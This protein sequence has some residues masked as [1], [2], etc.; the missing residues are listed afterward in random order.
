MLSRSPTSPPGGDGHVRVDRRRYSPAMATTIQVSEA[1]RDRLRAL[2]AP[3]PPS[4]RRSSRH[5][6]RSSVSSSGPPRACAGPATRHGRRRAGHAARCG[7]RR[8]ELARRTVSASA[9]DVYLADARDEVRRRV[10]V[11]SD[12][13]FHQA[14]GRAIV[15]PSIAVVA[16]DESPWRVG[17]TERF[18]TDFLTTIPLDR[19]LEAVGRV[20]VATLRRA[21]R[22]VT[23]S[24]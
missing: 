1:S 12:A 17:D 8:A 21:H 7:S 3:A 6:R 10:L 15:A 19:L 23:N 13:R 9:G 24:L 2:G 4:N 16:G 22:G 20:D 5:S 14:T 18:A 11:L